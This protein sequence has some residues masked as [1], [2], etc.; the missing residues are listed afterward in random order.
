MKKILLLVTSAFIL[1][2]SAM[3]SAPLTH[4]GGPID[5]GGG[6]PW[7][8]GQESEFPFIGVQ[9]IY[10]AEINQVPYFFSI[11]VIRSGSRLKLLNIRM[12][13]QTDCKLIAQG[14]GFNSMTNSYI[15]GSLKDIENYSNSFQISLRAF[16]EKVIE[17]G[18]VEPKFIRNGMV[19]VV[20]IGEFGQIMQVDQ[21]T[22]A[23]M[24]KVSSN[25]TKKC[26]P[27]Q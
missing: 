2:H 3:A 27:L 24:R 25:P 11:K 12:V 23:P 9:G 5:R 15:T 1:V 14:V 18:K 26:Q 22:S 6:T 17:P 8:W 13:D 20:S 7:P 4:S 10:V 21:M 19:M 16:A